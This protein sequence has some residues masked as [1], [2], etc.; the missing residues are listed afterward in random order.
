MIVTGMPC[1]VAAGTSTRSKP[2]PTR[3]TTRSRGPVIDRYA[4]SL[5]EHR[6][7]LTERDL[8]WVDDLIAAEEAGDANQQGVSA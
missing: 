7:V 4:R 1:R 8:Q 3:A 5:V 6:A 2:T